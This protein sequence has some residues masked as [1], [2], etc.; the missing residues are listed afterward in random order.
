MLLIYLESIKTKIGTLKN[1]NLVEWSTVV[2]DNAKASN[3]YTF[4]YNAVF[5]ED[6]A[7]IKI[8]LTK[9]KNDNIKIIG[10]GVFLRP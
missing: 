9:S 4:V 3:L 2:T 7:M 8:A 1:I 6:N 10:Y 5:E